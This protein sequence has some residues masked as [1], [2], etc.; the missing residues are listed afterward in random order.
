MI[1][2]R[3]II[4]NAVVHRD[5]SDQ[6]SCV[7][8]HAFDDRIE[9]ISPGRWG[10]APVTESRERLIG[11]LE[12]QSRKRNFRLAQTLTWSK[13]V[14]GVG[15]GVPRA[16]ADCES[17]GAPEPVVVTDEH[18]VR[19]TIFPR[20]PAEPAWRPS[21]TFRRRVLG[22]RLRELRTGL[23]LTVDEVADKLK[24]SASSAAWRRAPAGRTCVTSRSCAPCTTWTAR[25]PQG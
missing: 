25:P 14:E 1:A 6:E 9:I 23:G 12:R 17:A 15:A 13:L 22:L 3:E 11:Q 24:C 10:G 18:M 4:A 2:V 7:Q 20:P 21:G 8:V 19:V 5:Y 16:V